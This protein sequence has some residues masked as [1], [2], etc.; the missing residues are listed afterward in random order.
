MA[1]DK[2]VHRVVGM[3]MDY[4]GQILGSWDICLGAINY[5]EGESMVGKEERKL[6][7]KNM[8]SVKLAGVDMAL[9]K[10]LHKVVDMDKHC[11]DTLA[12]KG[13][14][15]G[16][17]VGKDLDFEMPGGKGMNFHTFEDKRNK[18]RA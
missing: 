3:V 4:E 15:F 18:S 13:M 16:K 9:D 7:D 12:D 6:V 11:P 17:A 5:M 10:L 8:V 2:A 1:A 14:A